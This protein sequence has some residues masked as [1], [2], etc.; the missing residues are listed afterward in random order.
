MPRRSLLT[1]IVLA[2]ASGCA[3]AI[4]VSSHRAPAHDWS[5][6]QTFAWTA[7]DAL[8]AADPRL[9]ANP[10]FG[11][12]MH[13]AVTSHLLA[14][15]WAEAAASAADI[16]IH[17]HA[18][19]TTRL[20]VARLDQ[21]YGSCPGGSC[22]GQTTE[23][24]AGTVVLDFV[25]ARTHRL[26]WRGWAQT[27]LAD[28]LRDPDRMAATINSSVTRMLALLPVTSPVRSTR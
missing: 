26:I 1:V 24:E 14:R 8:P 27:A 19:V 16:H 21:A 5:A 17:Y 22:P 4:N 25:D 2:A 7:P 10:I 6:Y 11:D 12:R 20:N 23:Y 28:L 3:A 18:S 15:G 13:G 9:S